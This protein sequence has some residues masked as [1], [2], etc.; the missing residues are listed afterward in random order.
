MSEG[1]G[2]L[3]VDEVDMIGERELEGDEEVAE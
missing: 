2:N 3:G 1:Q